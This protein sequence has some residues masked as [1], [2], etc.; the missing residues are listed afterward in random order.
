MRGD[1]AL[2]ITELDAAAL[3][4]PGDTRCVAGEAIARD[5][6]SRRGGAQALYRQGIGADRNGVVAI[7]DLAVSLAW[8]GQRSEATAVAGLLAGRS[9]LPERGML[10]GT[11][12]PSE[13][14][15]TACRVHDGGRSRRLVSGRRA[16]I[17]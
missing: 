8:S 16:V 4:Y 6:P 17:V 14:M 13:A 15:V 10:I 12:Q 5:M 3:A 7:T 9:G 1:A 2:G 11:E